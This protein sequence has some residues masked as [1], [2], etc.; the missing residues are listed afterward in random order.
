MFSVL[1]FLFWFYLVPLIGCALSIRLESKD[2]KDPRY[3]EARIFS[4]LPVVNLLAITLIA[5]FY[6][7]DFFIWLFNLVAGIK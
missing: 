5:V 1:T 6:I 3:R 7:W 2:K 4:L